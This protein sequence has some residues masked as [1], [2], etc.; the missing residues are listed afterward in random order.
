[1]ALPDPNRIAALAR[2]VLRTFQKATIRPSVDLGHVCLM[3]AAVL[4]EGVVTREAF[5]VLAGEWWDDVVTVESPVPEQERKPLQQ[6][7]LAGSFKEWLSTAL[8]TRND[9][10]SLVELTSMLLEAAV[11][12]AAGTFEAAGISLDDT[13]ARILGRVQSDV[14]VA[15]EFAQ[16]R[17]RAHATGEVH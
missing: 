12:T 3:H 16:A 15:Y 5:L 10:E 7:D 4:L 17:R 1:M 6:T 14:R 9:T 13:L 8:A 2:R 11:G